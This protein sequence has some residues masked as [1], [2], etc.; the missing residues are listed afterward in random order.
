MENGYQKIFWG[1]FLA[2]FNITIGSIK[3]V[4]AFVGWLVVL[5]GVNRLI[6]NYQTIS[7]GAAAKYNKILILT[8]LLGSLSSLLGAKIIEGSVLF[9]YYPIF[10]SIFEVIVIFKVL[11][12]SINYLK[13]MD[14]DSLAQEFEAKQRGYTIFWVIVNVVLIIGLTLYSEWLIGFGG[15]SLIVLRIYVMTSM[16]RLRKLELIDIED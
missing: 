13:S 7:F 15:L 8:L 6:E 2:T 14:E 10:S 11:E 16:S 3:I 9:L 4:P 5:S 1:V 12:G